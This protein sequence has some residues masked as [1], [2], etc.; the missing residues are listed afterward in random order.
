MPTQQ[1]REVVTYVKPSYLQGMPSFVLGLANIRGESIPIF[2]LNLLL[3]VEAKPTVV[4][5]KSCIIIVWLDNDK[6]SRLPACLLVDEITETYTIDPA[7][8][9][10]SISIAGR[11]EAE[12]LLGV[13]VIDKAMHLV[14]SMETLIHPHLTGL[15][16]EQVSAV[17]Q[18]ETTVQQQRSRGV[19]RK[20]ISVFNKGTCFAFSL[21]NVR[22]ILPLPDKVDHNHPDFL[23]GMTMFHNEPLGLLRINVGTQE[24][25]K[26]A[27]A[28]PEVV[29]VFQLETIQLGLV[30]DRLGDVY[31]R[32]DADIKPATF[33]NEIARQ[34]LTSQGILETP[35]GDIELIDSLSLLT[36]TETQLIESWYRAT[37]RI[38]TSG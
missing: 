23:C 34:R 15:L 33:C 30:V 3:D 28:N 9:M 26:S 24:Y 29:V 38:I 20:F 2:D 22:Q 13:A 36:N 35:Q 11:I 19:L 14:I 37:R 32:Y 7:N 31:E 27:D 10:T 8:F 17:V 16:H 5:E 25:V 12:Y 6:A 1:I 18:Q 21:K 4:H